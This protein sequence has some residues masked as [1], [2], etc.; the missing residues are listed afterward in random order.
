MPA[1]TCWHISFGDAVLSLE[2]CCNS[3]MCTTDLHLLVLFVAA[4]NRAEPSRMPLP[5]LSADT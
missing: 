3:T 2:L 4:V 5:S 1:K